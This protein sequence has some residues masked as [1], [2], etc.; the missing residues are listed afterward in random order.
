MQTTYVFGHRNPD[1]DSVCAA[2]S[3]S[4]L[5]NKLGDKTEPK[6]LGSINKES[7]FVLD[8]FK[9]KEPAYLNDVRIQ[10]RNINYHKKVM[11]NE[12]TSLADAFEYMQS[13]NI[14]GVPIID[15][16]KALKGLVTLKEILKE[17]VTGDT[18]KLHTSYNNLLSVLNA[19]EVFR[20]DEEIEGDLLAATFYSGT[21]TEKVELTDRS[22]LIVGDRHK[23]LDYAVN[24]K[25]KMIISI[26]NTEIPKEFLSIAKKNKINIIRTPFTSYETSNKIRLSMY[27]KDLHLNPNPVSVDQFDYRDD[28]IEM[29]HKCGHTNY[30]VVNKKGECLGL[31]KATQANDY[32]KKKVMLV[33]HNQ[34]EQSVPGIEDATIEG[35]VDHHNLG[36]IGTTMPI[37][38][39]VMPVGCSCTVIYQL[40]IESGIAIPKDIAGLMLSAILSDT[41]LLKSPTT[42][43]M[44]VDVVKK[45]EKICKIKQ[46]IYGAEMFKAGASIDGMTPEEVFYQDFKSYKVEDKSL[47]I[48]QI[49]TMDIEEINDNIDKYVSLLNTI[50]YRDYEVVVM[51]ITDV[52]NNGSYILY[53]NKAKDLVGE[54]FGIKDITEGTFIKDLVSRKKQMLPDLMEAIEKNG[55]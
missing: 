46:S 6:V 41:L 2:V 37:N 42:T 44:D 32:E 23:I 16:N 45:L 15:S 1:T 51:F 35:I 11:V 34:A 27:V 26:S 25:V 24:S 9:I 33:D 40:Y 13:K 17:I 50:A 38:F 39:R 5:R 54:A 53:N 20:F 49:F 18:K 22:V 3:L 30:P 14:T 10:I 55:N 31:V 8:Y 21:F 36:T 29:S 47:G 48:S 52:I 12:N 19:K 43:E 28:F 4:Y 7:K